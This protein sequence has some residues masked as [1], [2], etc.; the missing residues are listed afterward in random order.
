MP[1]SYPT[2]PTTG[3]RATVLGIHKLGGVHIL[4]MLNSSA[5]DDILRFKD[6]HGL[7]AGDRVKVV[8]RP[9]GAGSSILQTTTY[10]VMGNA[11]LTDTTFQISTVNEPIPPVG[12]PQ[13]FGS[14]FT[15]T[16]SHGTGWWTAVV[17]PK[18]TESLLWDAHTLA[19]FDSH[20]AVIRSKR[21]ISDAAAGIITV[22]GVTST[23]V[24][25]ATAHGL[26][27]GDRV[28]FVSLTGGYKLRRGLTY[29][30]VNK[31]A[32]DFQISETLGGAAADLGADIS[33]AKLRKLTVGG[34]R[35]ISPATTLYP[36]ILA[37]WLHVTSDVGGDYSKATWAPSL[38]ILNG[39]KDRGAV[40]MINWNWQNLA[41]WQNATTGGAIAYR[42]IYA[43]DWNAQIDA[44]ANRIQSYGDTVIVRMWWE[45]NGNWFP[46]FYG[47][48]WK[49]SDTETR[50]TGN[51]YAGDTNYYLGK[52]DHILAWRYVVE[53]VRPLTGGSN[54]TRAANGSWSVVPTPG[55]ARFFW[56]P[57]DIE[58]L[59]LQ[60]I[61][62]GSEW[63]DYVGWDGYTRHDNGAGI[64]WITETNTNQDYIVISGG[65]NMGKKLLP[66][67]RVQVTTLVGSSGL[68]LGGIYFVTRAG[69]GSAEAPRW[70]LRTG[71]M[72]GPVVNLTGS[73]NGT[74]LRGAPSMVKHYGAGV[75]KIR[76]L[77]TGSEST[78]SPVPIIL[79]ETGYLGEYVSKTFEAPA[80][81][82]T[83]GGQPPLSGGSM[84]PNS[85][86]PWTLPETILT[87]ADDERED[88][89]ADFRKQ[90]LGKG[91]P[92]MRSAYPDL[93]GFIYFDCDMMPR[94]GQGAYWPA[95]WRF[96]ARPPISK[97]WATL[98]NQANMRGT[99][100]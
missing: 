70:Q 30:V 10:F 58:N 69:G 47:A 91:L 67:D 80:P 56:C 27:N 5:S 34:V 96:D 87:A 23:D 38:G 88:D 60:D 62:P 7:R 93:V 35:Q 2:N 18:A 83:Y 12:S 95:N 51:W 41:E 39:I 76:K 14:D 75:R 49:I 52:K 100:T 72:R 89:L 50:Q 26:S 79:G 94:E 64:G 13:D 11:N 86:T 44:V 57:H 98:S 1:L 24:I 55:K 99:I 48:E 3:Q 61:Y 25:S 97:R 33:T 28:A 45:Q 17:A 66:G 63:V 8:H 15:G 68:T 19:G 73:A 84:M 92:A 77:L 9:A 42:R 65:G 82:P 31:N 20:E 16:G 46:W 90:W 4:E 40:P 71:S 36:R 59:Y 78:Q 21:G 43:G 22:T 54:G 32:N 37:F 74:I 53:R 81:D 85:S 6:T 29:Y